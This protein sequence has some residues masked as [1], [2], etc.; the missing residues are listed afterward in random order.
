VAISHHERWDGSGYPK[1]LKGEAIPMAGRIV[2]VAD[3]FDAI[4]N[5]R[6]YRAARPAGVAMQLLRN[7][8]DRQFEG[9]LVDAV[10]RIVSAESH[11]YELSSCPASVA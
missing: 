6:P 4:T 2:A 1:G 10:E 8:S 7:D 3:A 9:R 11:P 5:S